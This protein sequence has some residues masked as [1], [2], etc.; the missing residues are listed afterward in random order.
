MLIIKMLLGFAA[1]LAV[2]LLLWA[3]RG[4]ALTPVR[5]GKNER[6]AVVLTVTGADPGLEQT[7]DGLL[8]LR[9]NGTLRAR[10]LVRDAGMDEDPRRAAEM[11]EKK[12]CVE[13]MLE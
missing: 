10:L 9:Q 12:G 7:V 4:A 1:A 11:R 3:A 5:P 6:L 8:W 2:M 13:L